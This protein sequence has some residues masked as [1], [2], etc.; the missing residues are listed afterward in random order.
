MISGLAARPWC[1][2]KSEPYLTLEESENVQMSS[3]SG[4]SKGRKC[5]SSIYKGAPRNEPGTCLCQRVVQ[6]SYSSSHHCIVIRI[7][8]GGDSLVLQWLELG[9]F[10]AR[11]GIQSLVRELGFHMPHDAAKKKKYWRKNFL[12]HRCTGSTPDLL[13]QDY[14][15]WAL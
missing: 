9:T 4:R 15:G 5:K 10:T 6:P 7:N 3:S 12:K 11:A 2:Q 13:N 1:C 14:Q 8:Q